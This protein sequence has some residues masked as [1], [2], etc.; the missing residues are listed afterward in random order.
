MHRILPLVPFWLLARA[1]FNGQVAVFAIAAGAEIVLIILLDW[2]FSKMPFT[3][4]SGR[5]ASS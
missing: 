2:Y 4:L 5:A 3:K 1:L